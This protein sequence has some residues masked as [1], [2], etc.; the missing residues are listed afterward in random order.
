MSRE[1]DEIKDAAGAYRRW[2][3]EARKKYIELRL[4]QDP[5]I[6]GLYIRA[7]DRVAK[8]LRSLVLKTPSSYL[9]KRQLEELEV[10]LKVEADRLAGNLEKVLGS[11]I[12]QAVDAGGG[13]SQAITLDL[14][15]KAGLDTSGLRTMFAAVNR[16]AV[17]ACWARTK[18]GLFLSD[19]I[20]Q[21]GENFRNTMR[22]L[23]QEAVATGQDA[24]K[25]ARMLQQYIRQGAQTLAR[26]YPNMM[27]RMGNRVPKDICY[28]A[29][30]LA[31]TEM[32]AAFGEGTVAA[33]R[34]SPSYIGMKWVLS[35]SHPMVDICDALAEHDEGL[36]RGVYS[37]GD[38]PHLPAHPNCICSLVP[39]H[40]EPEKF[41]ERL[42]K[43]R[44]D[45]SSEPELEKWYNDIYKVGAKTGKS[46]AV[47]K[48]KDFTP[49]EI[50]GVKRGKPMTRDEAN[51]GRPNPN[52]E[53]NEAYKSNCQSCVVC[54]EARLR[55]Y[56]VMTRP[57]GADDI[58]ERLA[59][60]TNL[61]W[62]D[63]LTGEHPEY[64][65]DDKIDT[66]KKF[67][68][69]LE[70]NVEKGK[71]YTLQFSWKGKS[72]MGHIVS[73]DRDENNLLRIYDPQ[74]GKT[75]SGDIVGRYL[76]QIKYV[77]TVYGVK[78]P[79]RPKIMRIDDKEFNLDVVNRV[80]EGAK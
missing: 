4:R 48:T 6:R 7:A 65:Y 64:I 38:E 12:E 78:M 22:D 36:G 24:I 35:H 69:F 60:Q 13:Y 23:V 9:R 74:C 11:Y 3:L 58:M 54:Y 66:A 55:G 57:Y 50:A 21:Q 42:K 79:T 20:W 61:A 49:D 44:D 80:L 34:V 63:P 26:D 25:T 14:F 43:W 70:E 56:D 27:E 46:V 28:E 45:P 32:T 1:I 71:R 37:P 73:L 10:A 68:K 51:K 40:E 72:R 15:K 19:R 18:K 75:Y 62:I 5:E 16:Q 33:A 47:G 2:A 41:V 76:Q 59:T 52:Y 17:E 29:L 39:V 77:Q 31:R 67:L 8:E 30:R 53:L